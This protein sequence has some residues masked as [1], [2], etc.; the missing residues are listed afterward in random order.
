[1]NRLRGL[2]AAAVA[3]TGTTVI[4]AV[5]PSGVAHAAVPVFINEIHYD[6]AGTDAGEGVEIAGPA[7]T[8]V[9]G[10]QLVPYN[11]SGGGTYSPI[12]TFPAGT[13]IPDQGTG[14]GAL[15]A[16]ISGLQ[17]GAPDGI[18]LVDATP[19]VVQF[20]SYEGAFAATNGPAAGLTS[21][22]IGV[23]Q[24]GSDAIGL[25]LQLVGSG[26][27]DEDFTWTGP[28]DDSP[29]TLN[30]NQTF[31]GAPAPVAVTNPGDR[32]A[33]IDIEIV[34]IQLAASG[35]TPPYTWSA[36]VLPAGLELTGNTIAGTPTGPAGPVA[37]TVTATD[38]A[39]PAAAA[40]ATFTID[41]RERPTTSPIGAVQGPGAATPVAGQMVAVQGVVVGDY[42]GAGTPTLR[43]FYLQS[44]TPD[45]D[46]LT[47]DAIFVFNNTPGPD[48]VNLGDLVT[49]VGIAG[50]NQDQTQITALLIEV[51]GS[52]HTI[53]PTPIDLPWDDAAEPESYEGM[54]VTVPQT[55]YV[56]EYFQTARFG[57]VVVSSV[58]HLPQPTSIVP[59]GQAAI[60]LQAANNLTKLVLDDGINNQNAD[61]LAMYVNGGLIS[62]TNPLRGGDTIAG[63]TGVLTYTWAGNS[64]SGNKFRL[65]PVTTAAVPAFDFATANP[66]PVDPPDVGG[67]LE[68]VGFNVL[69][70]FVTLGSGPNCGTPETLPADR[71]CRGASN[72]GEYERQHAKLIAAL[73]DIDADVYGFA[74]LE[75]TTGVDTLAPIVASLNAA[76]GA[77]VWA[78]AYD[79]TLGTDVIKVGIIYRTDKVDLLGTATLTSAFSEAF[80]DSLHRPSLAASFEE[81]ATGE[82]LTVVVNHWKSTGSCPAA[83]DPLAEGNVDSGDGASCWNA[84]RTDAAETMLDWL[85][86]H[87]T[88]VDDDDVLVFGDLNSYAMESP[89]QTL[90]GAGYVDLV[91]AYDPGAHS[92]VFDGQWGTLDY[93]L[94]SPSLAAQVT[95][96][97]DYHINADEVPLMDYNTD[98]QSA[99]QRDLWYA[100]DPFRT[101]DHDPAVVGIALDSVAPTVTVSYTGASPVTTATFD[102]TV[103]FSEDVTGFDDVATDVV[104]SGPAGVAAT[105]ISGSGSSY[106][107]TLSVPLGA[108][109]SVS[110]SVPAGAAADATG[111]PSAVSNS[112]DVA[113]DRVVPVVFDVTGFVG[114]GKVVIASGVLTGD[115]AC[116]APIEFS[117]AGRTIAG[118]PTSRLSRGVCTSTLHAPGGSLVLVREQA[119]GTWAV[120]ANFRS[121]PGY[122]TATPV[123]LEVG[124]SSGSET[125]R[126]RKLFGAWLLI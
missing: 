4:A 77:D 98:F 68:V 118:T 104:V 52:G 9:G 16:P 66:R 50:E 85:A 33:T 103:Q 39:T 7:G 48:D 87:P 20:L 117:V 83:S 19:A 45:D 22:D 80:D 5:A 102:V 6:N 15:W 110:V 24:S 36:D 90:V 82:Q 11:G 38:S 126:L 74:E 58:D 62:A 76:A 71:N 108:S 109:G 12:F 14:Y 107:V 54:L 61:P 65:R 3:L 29:G 13:A 34:P 99:G 27:T 17:N 94:A 70:Y 57:E 46:P 125:L 91:Q 113:A 23:V 25:T 49:V 86:T 81:L 51:D 35:G 32:T 56:T 60:D 100:P 40:T 42:E 75:N 78:S 105:A 59:P 73:V 93:A 44:V 79:G 97:A 120:V 112:V 55:M 111:N 124:T 37:V 101:S 119:S 114:T 121:T 106:T 1:M 26:T 89:I 28:V 63:A 92:Y 2:V 116:G 10:W 122:T 53:A 47:S 69:N 41:V 115:V 95:G 88:G 67:S 8:D 21:V 31:G 96:A 84:A 123:A 72:A 18:A 43:G 64:S 30:A